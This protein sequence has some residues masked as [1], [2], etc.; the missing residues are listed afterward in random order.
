MRRPI[1]V[2]RHRFLEQ[3]LQVLHQQF[4][5]LFQV[6]NAFV[7]LLQQ[8]LESHNLLQQTRIVVELQVDRSTDLCLHFSRFPRI[9][10]QRQ[11]TLNLCLQLSDLLLQLLN[12]RV[13]LR[14][15]RL[16]LLLQFLDLGVAIFQQILQF[17]DARRLLRYLRFVVLLNALQ[18]SNACFQSLDLVEQLLDSL[19]FVL[20]LFVFLRHQLLQFL[21]ARALVLDGR[22][23]LFV[24]RL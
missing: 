18:L 10:N 20:Q 13:L 16:F 22:F 23:L 11:Q 19:V 17:L 2:K 7:L 6:G 15:L 12:L 3:I 9:I 1:A 14:N 4:V 21:D 24:L 5:L 8:L